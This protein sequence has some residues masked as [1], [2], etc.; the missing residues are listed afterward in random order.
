MNPGKLLSLREVLERSYSRYVQVLPSGLRMPRGDIE[1]D[2]VAEVVTFHPARTRYEDRKP[3]CRSLDGVTS[4]DKSCSC[5]SCLLRNRCTPQICLE[6][7]YNSIPIRILL[8]Y[9]SMKNFLNV[10]LTLHAKQKSLESETI[11]IQVRNRG[12]WGELVFSLPQQPTS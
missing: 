3:I 6:L 9:T 4:L 8:S 12:R 5:I 1:T 7:R 2:I 10:S 11:R